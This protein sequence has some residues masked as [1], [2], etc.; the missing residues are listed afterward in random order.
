MLPTHRTL[1]DFREKVIRFTSWFEIGV[2]IYSQ[3][4]YTMETLDVYGRHDGKEVVNVHNVS[5]HGSC[6]LWFF[7]PQCSCSI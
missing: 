4:G 1:A 3:D 7:L 2:L 5:T 6:F